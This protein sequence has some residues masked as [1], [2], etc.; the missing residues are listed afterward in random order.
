LAQK[1]SIE[2]IRNEL[3][4]KGIDVEYLEEHFNRKFAA[5]NIEGVRLID[6]IAN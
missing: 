1:K 5:V 4:Q 3:T 2:E 6:N